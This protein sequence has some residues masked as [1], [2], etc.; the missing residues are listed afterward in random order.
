MLRNKLANRITKTISTIFQ[1]S[2]RKTSRSALLL[3]LVCSACKPLLTTDSLPA[4]PEKVAELPNIYRQENIAIAPPSGWQ[5]VKVAGIKYTVFSLDAS[6]SISLVEESF[7]GDLQKYAQS[8]L[9]GMAIAFSNWQK[10][11][12]SE[13]QTTPGTNTR[14]I[15]TKGMSG[16]VVVT[17]SQQLNQLLHQRIYFFAPESASDRKL[18]VICGGKPEAAAELQLTCDASLKTLAISP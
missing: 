10:I 15:T 7:S 9:Q 18:I 3:M 8:S 2:V 1:F 5:P 6:T 4:N 17:Q 14:Q 16:K 11:S 12:E 13:F